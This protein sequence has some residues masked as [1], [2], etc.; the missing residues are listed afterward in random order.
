MIRIFCDNLPGERDKNS[1]PFENTVVAASGTVKTLY[2]CCSNLI[3]MY[4]RALDLPAQGPNK[5]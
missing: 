1:A 3:L 5:H 4:D 2:P